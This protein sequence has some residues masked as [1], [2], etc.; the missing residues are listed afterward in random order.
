MSFERVQNYIR[1][2]S[3]RTFVCV[4]NGKAKCMDADNEKVAKI[5]KDY[6]ANKERAELVP[7]GFYTS[8]VAEIDLAEDLIEAGVTT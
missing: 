8:D 2:H 3:R 7:V 5:L 1:R 6:E 4:Q